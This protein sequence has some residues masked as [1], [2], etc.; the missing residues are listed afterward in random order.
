ME[1]SVKQIRKRGIKDGISNAFTSLFSSFG[2]LVLLAIFIF[3]CTNGFHVLS[4][5]F[6]TSD[7]NPSIA[8][9][10]YPVARDEKVT[11][12][13]PLINGVYFSSGWGVGFEDATNAAKEECVIVTYLDNKSPLKNLV[14]QSTQDFYALTLGSSFDSGILFTT[15]GDLVLSFKKDGAMKMAES[16][17]QGVKISSLTVSTSG[18][19]IRGSLLSTIYMIFFT[20][21]FALPLGILSALY[22]EEYSKDSKMNKIIRTLI[23]VSGGIPSIIYGLIGALVFIP[24]VNFF[25][26]SKGGSLLSG[27][28][29]LAIMLLPTIIASTSEAIKAMPHSYTSASLALGASK[30]QTV[31]K[32][33]LPYSLPGILTGVLLS[34]GRII[35][36]SAA[37]IYSCGTAIK[38]QIILTGSSSTLAIHIWS[39]LGQETPDFEAASAVAIIILLADLILSIAVKLMGIR[40]ER[41]MKGRKQN[42]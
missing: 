24:V 12:K 17:D 8:T 40:I 14:D 39:L 10:A 29:T 25:S 30:T 38:D 4:W 37:L 33:V 16:F 27:A 21:L 11:Y 19:G 2:V 9:C 5:S 15:S 3:V 1:T 6:L 41:K 28:L 32:I 18:G 42:G 13:D 26:G 7:Y 31:F 34:I 35:G 20:L 22:L 36:E 23:D